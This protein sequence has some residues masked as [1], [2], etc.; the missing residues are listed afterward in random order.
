MRIRHAKTIAARRG[1][2]LLALALAC[3][4][5]LTGCSAISNLLPGEDA[6]EAEERA[7]EDGRREERDSDREGERD[8]DRDD[9]DRGSDRDRDD[10]RDRNEDD[11]DDDSL[12][13]HYRGNGVSL[14]YP[15]SWERTDAE[16]G[17]T[18]IYLPTGGMLMVNAPFDLGGDV[19]TVSAATIDGFFE[20][21][22][23]GLESSGSLTV[24]DSERADDDGAYVLLCQVEANYDGIGYQGFAWVC[25][26]DTN[27]Y[28]VMVMDVDETYD[29]NEDVLIEVMDT[30]EL[31]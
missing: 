11:E 6:G 13:E 1:S 16:G 29:E 24:V 14:R 4:L 31:S 20:D 15:S 3:A 26:N 10:G 27:C 22:L 9:E 19:S 23:E 5:A 17:I 21:Y 7:E 28:N 2:L 25:L 8:S 30:V 12:D 18:Y